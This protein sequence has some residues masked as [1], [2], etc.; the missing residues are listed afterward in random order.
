ALHGVTDSGACWEPVLAGWAAERAGLT[1]DARGHGGTPLPADGRLA[2]SAVARDVAA[3]VRE[4][5]RDVVGPRVVAVGHS[6]GGLV[7]EELALADPGLVAGLVLEDPAWN[8][9]RDLDAA[10]VPTW[11][12]PF[13]ASFAGA[14]Q[15]QL[16]ARSRRENAGW[17]DAEHAPWAA[18]KRQVDPRLGEG[19]HEWDE[20]DWVPALAEVQVPVLL[21]TG[22]VDRGAIVDDRLLEGARAALGDRLTHVAV[23][24]AGHSV[25]REAPAAFLEAVDAFLRQVD[26]AAG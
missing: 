15:E 19:P 26:R 12:P 11:L 22:D 6:M 3:A 5:V 10:G 24:S 20:R 8:R 4:V 18:S 7:A 1:V 9:G 2:I 14:T 17:P 25:R 13:V 21:V 23:P 16:E